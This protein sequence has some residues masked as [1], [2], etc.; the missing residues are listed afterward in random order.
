[1]HLR[2]HFNQLFP[3]SKPQTCQFSHLSG[4]NCV[5]DRQSNK[6]G[7]SVDLTAMSYLPDTRYW[8]THVVL[9]TLLFWLVLIEKSARK[10]HN[11]SQTENLRDFFSTKSVIKDT[12]WFSKTKISERIEIEKWRAPLIFGIKK[13]WKF[14]YR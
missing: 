12:I 10:I 13:C 6:N 5:V 7:C 11:T 1:M 2:H 14:V 4:L 8:L 9:F 3:E